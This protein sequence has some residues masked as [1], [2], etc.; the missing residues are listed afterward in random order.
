M[1][2]IL[3]FEMGTTFGIS[4]LHRFVFIFFGF[5]ENRN[6]EVAIITLKRM[7]LLQFCLYSQV[8]Y[9]LCIQ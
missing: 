6:S 7:K 3:R 2:E 4:F 9:I 5:V 8:S 1:N